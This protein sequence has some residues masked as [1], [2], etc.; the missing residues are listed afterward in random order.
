MKRVLLTLS[1]LLFTA[2]AAQ[3]TLAP[4]DRITRSGM[5]ALASAA[6]LSTSKDFECGTAAGPTGSEADACLLSDEEEALLAASLLVERMGS[7]ATR[8]AEERARR[9]EQQD[10]GALARL[11]HEIAAFASELVGPAAASR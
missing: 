1:A 2:S 9:F 3:A 7:E 4:D 10:D 8:F 5:E 11:W 6:S